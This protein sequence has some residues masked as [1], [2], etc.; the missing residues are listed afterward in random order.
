MNE[1]NF[2]FEEL[3][4]WK[5]AREFKKEAVAEARKFPPEEKFRLTEQLIRSASSISALIA[6]GHGR[7][8]YADQIP[9]DVQV[10]GPLSES[11]NHLIEAH[12]ETYIT[13]EKLNYYKKK[14]KKLVRLINGYIAYLRKKRDEE[15][16][17]ALKSKITVALNLPNTLNFI[18]FIYLFT[19][20]THQ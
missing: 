11:I 5:K 16:Q 6:E 4:V 10:R 18:Y 8:T 12:D 1:L 7:F 15:K 9:Y 3:E 19:F 13:F 17:Q 20:Q 2:G 14:G